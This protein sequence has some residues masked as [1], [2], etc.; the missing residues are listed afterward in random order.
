MSLYYIVIG[1]L[2]L[3]FVLLGYLWGLIYWS[4]LV[5]V[6]NAG[7]HLIATGKEAKDRRKNKE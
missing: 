7:V 2:G 3:P 1:L 6:D 4:W 5:G